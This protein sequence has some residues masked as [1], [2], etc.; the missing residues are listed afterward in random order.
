MIAPLLPFPIRGVIFYQGES[1]N[2]R[3][4]QYRTLFPALIADWRAAW[5][6]ADMPFLF[7]QIAPFKSMRPELREAQLLAWQSTPGTA[8]V[9]TTDCGD[10]EDIHPANKAPVGSRL[11]LAA[12][13]IA[14]GEKIDYSGP[15]FDQISFDHDRTWLTFAHRGGGLAC[16]DGGT[17]LKGF[18][19]AG[20]D[21]V[22]HPAL[23]G[24]KGERV[25]VWS[26][27]VRE[28][29][30]VRY[31]WANVPEGNL[32]NR[33]G[34]PASPFRTDVPPLETTAEAAK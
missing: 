17:Q 31:G 14:Y 4:A 1:N 34:L 30:A 6:R 18:T 26:E 8:M 22:F 21:G 10:A 28:P 19:V 16:A 33:S 15:V 20:K 24:I 13:A 25:L 12:R 3:A 23:A 32:V 9:V 11:A 29:V 27:K 2:D 5:E 7:V